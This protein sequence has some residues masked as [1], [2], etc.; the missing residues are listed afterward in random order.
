M[1][2]TKI[3][4]RCRT[5][6]LAGRVIGCHGPEPLPGGNRTGVAATFQPLAS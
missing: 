5:M 3:F 4:I 1:S 2:M 6:S